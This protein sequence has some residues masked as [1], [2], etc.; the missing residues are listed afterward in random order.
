M[1]MNAKMNLFYH[2]TSGFLSV[3]RLAKPTILSPKKTGS[4]DDAKNLQSDWINVGK[5]IRKSYEQFKTG[6][7][8][9]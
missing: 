4:E 3:F 6:L 8:A 2:F 9:I 7:R 1:I 5:D